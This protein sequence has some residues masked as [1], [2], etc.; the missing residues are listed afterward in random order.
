M[1][2]SDYR[3]RAS[4][5]VVFHRHLNLPLDLDCPETYPRNECGERAVAAVTQK[6]E[7]GHWDWFL[8]LIP[9]CEGCSVAEARG[10]RRGNRQL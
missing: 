10:G 4:K 2:E 6:A 3:R 1:S 5:T 9:N 7:L 8:R